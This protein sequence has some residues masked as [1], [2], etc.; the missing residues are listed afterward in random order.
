MGLVQ[1][2]VYFPNGVQDELLGM[3]LCTRCWG[4]VG[5]L[6]HRMAEVGGTC[7]GISPTPAAAGQPKNGSFQRGVPS[8]GL[9]DPQVKGFAWGQHRHSAPCFPSCCCFVPMVVSAYPSLIY[10]NYF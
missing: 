5:M 6:N 10:D 4:I 2:W 8:S 1:K 3:L 9:W 7:R